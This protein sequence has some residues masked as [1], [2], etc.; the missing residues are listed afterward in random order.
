M[1]PIER[2]D[3]VAEIARRLFD[4]ERIGRPIDPT[5]LA[6]AACVL[7]QRPTLLQQHPAPARVFT[8]EAA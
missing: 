7:D 8:T 1:T 6:W 5:R 2:D 4:E 3:L